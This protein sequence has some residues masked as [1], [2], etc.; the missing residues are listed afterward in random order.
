MLAGAPFPLCTEPVTQGIY[1]NKFHGP[2]AMVTTGLQ[3]VSSRKKERI[4][5]WRTNNFVLLQM[6]MYRVKVNLNWVG[7]FAV[8][9]TNLN[10]FT[11]GTGFPVTLAVSVR[12]CLSWTVYKLEN[13]VHVTL[14]YF[15]ILKDILYCIASRHLLGWTFQKH[16]QW[17]RPSKNKQVLTK[18]Q[19]E[20]RLQD[21][22]V[23]Y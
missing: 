7:L 2:W 6:K 12:F 5:I 18:A 13:A 4:R 11:D 1:T 23:K 17:A 10:H 8:N 22:S 3:S 9:E 14:R 19:E 15:N 16:C 21:R 20:E